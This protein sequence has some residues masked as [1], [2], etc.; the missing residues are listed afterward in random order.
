ML[1]E[2]VF[3]GATGKV[4]DAAFDGEAIPTIIR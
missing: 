1:E 2:M 3:D 4:P